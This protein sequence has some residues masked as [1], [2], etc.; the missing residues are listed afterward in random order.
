MIQ[1]FDR[2][3]KKV[4]QEKVAGE[5][6]LKFFYGNS[7]NK[8]LVSKFF[9]L[10]LTKFPVAS[11]IFGWFQKRSFTKRKIQPF[12]QAYK[13]NCSEFLKQEFDSFNDFFTRKLNLSYRPIAKSNFVMPADGR[14]LAFPIISDFVIKGK[15]FNLKSF[16][17]DD[18]L[19]KKYEK[20]SMV[21]GRLCPSDYHRF[22]FPCD[23]IASNT[24]VINGRYFSVNPLAISARFSIFFENKRVLTEIHTKDSGS[25]MMIEVGATFVGSICQTFIPDLPVKKGDEKGYFEFGGST[26]VLLFEPGKIV[27]DE[28]IVKKTVEGIETYCLMGSSLGELGSKQ[29]CKP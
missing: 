25:I 14:Y 8:N 20:G 16:L 11:Y 13:V 22:H 19:L 23:G 12:I 4:Y 3:R 10:L 29:D 7:Y 5:F 6:W 28:E 18:L 21:I 9:L 17:Q 24:K 27:L 26:V 1:Y 2:N 15:H